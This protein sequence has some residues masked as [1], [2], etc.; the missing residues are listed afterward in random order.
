MV[1]AI[2]QI[3]YDI[4]NRKSIEYGKAWGVV[5]LTFKLD[6]EEERKKTLAMVMAHELGHMVSFVPTI[7]ITTAISVGLCNFKEGGS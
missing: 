6:N 2:K 3:G 1:T 4:G 7:K 5:D